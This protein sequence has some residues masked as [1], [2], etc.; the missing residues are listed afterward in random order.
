MCYNISDMAT[1]DIKDMI[2]DL[3]GEVDEAS[4]IY[5]LLL[6]DELELRMTEKDFYDFTEHIGI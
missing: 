4:D 3:F 5:F 2:N 1:E 6:L